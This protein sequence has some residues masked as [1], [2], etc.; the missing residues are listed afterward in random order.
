MCVAHLND[1]CASAEHTKCG[2][3][4]DKLMQTSRTCEIIHTTMCVYVCACVHVHVQV[5]R[6]VTIKHYPPLHQ[7]FLL[8]LSC[9]VFG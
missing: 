3:L 9:V 8:V 2:L 4:E 1:V 5:N 6:C 7:P